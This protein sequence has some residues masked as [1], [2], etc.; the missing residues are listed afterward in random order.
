MAEF[1]LTLTKIVVFTDPGA[2]IDDEILLHLL[3]KSETK[4]K[5]IYFVCVP[6]ITPN[7][8]PSTS[9]SKAKS[10]ERM[11]RVKAMFP[12][13]F[14]SSDQWSPYPEDATSSIFKLCTSH[15]FFEGLTS[16]QPIKVQTLL[17]V[18][19]LWHVDPED[20]QKLEIDTRI[21]MGDLQNPKLSINGTKAM[22]QCTEG[23]QLRENYL[24]QEL[25]LQANTEKTINIPSHFARQ[26]PTP[27]AFVDAL[28]E[29]LKTPLLGTAFA[30][31]VGRP[32]PSFS[33]AKDISVVNHATILKMLPSDVLYDI[34]VHQG[35]NTVYP[36]LGD[37]P[38]HQT[39]RFLATITD[40][41]YHVR[42]Q[43]I[44]QAVYY[45][46]QV[47]YTNDGFNQDALENKELAKENWCAYLQQHR[48][49]LSPFYDGLA[50]VVLK[51]GE[52]PDL[53][54]CNEIV[55][56]LAHKN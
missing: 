48:C 8:S 56:G 5:D 14:G 44:A 45:I 53:E 26:V 54:R 33:W 34:L 6:G 16:N 42:L 15:S 28:P 10:E 40:H 49:N 25:V 46:T 4:G 29:T 38:T 17:H 55:Q 51:E 3:M 13:Q 47:K 21:F 24:R 1:P 50:W 12:E 31:F 36:S 30:Q 22:P 23:D 11:R 20:L 7:Y 43:Q 52:L 37:Q 9:E 32:D 19:P 35:K 2:E 41:D 39:T 27:F 18:A